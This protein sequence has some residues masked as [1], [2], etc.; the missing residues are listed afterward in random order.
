M[1]V[2]KIPSTHEFQIFHHSKLLHS[3]FQFLKRSRV[4]ETAAMAET[5]ERVTRSL[6][7]AINKLGCSQL[8]S[9]SSWQHNPTRAGP[10]PPRARRSPVASDSRPSHLLFPR[11]VLHVWWEG[12]RK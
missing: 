4:T 9:R 11:N 10:E 5:N 8:R 3:I 6:P 12:R 1:N 7:N 2:L